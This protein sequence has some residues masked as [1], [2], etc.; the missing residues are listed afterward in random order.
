MAICPHCGEDDTRYVET[1]CPTPD[2]ESELM[3][4]AVCG[5]CDYGINDHTEGQC[6]CPK[7]S[8]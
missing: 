7:V 8:A 6:D 4:F 5:N 2:G 1:T 3:V